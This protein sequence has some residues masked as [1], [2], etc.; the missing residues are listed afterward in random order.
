[1]DFISSFDKQYD[2]L[3]KCKLIEDRINKL[4]THFASIT[5]VLNE[6]KTI[7]MRNNP[8]GA[9]ETLNKLDI[10]PVVTP[11]QYT[12]QKKE[13]YTILRQAPMHKEEPS[14]NTADVPAAKRQ[15]IEERSDVYSPSQ[16]PLRLDDEQT[17]RREL[18][19]EGEQ[20]NIIITPAELEENVS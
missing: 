4:I 8:N 16:S 5:E 10:K 18:R 1:M 19:Q 2:P 6:K 17:I 7:L 14:T 3:A 20:G 15:R 9:K 12:F 11:G 13:G